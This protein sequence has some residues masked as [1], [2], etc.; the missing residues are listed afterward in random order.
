M[1][2]ET[3]TV[4][5][6]DV[7]VVYAPHPIGENTKAELKAEIKETFGDIRILILDQ[8]KTLGVLK[9]PYDWAGAL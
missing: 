6:K 2:N 7:L 1:K 3:V 9:S 4:N 5:G 8:N